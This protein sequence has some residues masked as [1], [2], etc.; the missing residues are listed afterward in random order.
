MSKE[1]K[2]EVKT[3]PI[4]YKELS[5]RLF[6]DGHF[7]SGVNTGLTYDEA[8]RMILELE[9]YCCN[10]LGTHPLLLNAHLNNILLEHLFVELPKEDEDEKNESGD[11]KLMA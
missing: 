10:N 8:V 6:A 2:D 9:L 7:E 4:Q 11:D 1:D 5:C 3:K